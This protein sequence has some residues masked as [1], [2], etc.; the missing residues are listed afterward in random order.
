MRARYWFGVV[1]LAALGGLFVGRRT[2]SN[3]GVSTTERAIPIKGGSPNVELDLYSPPRNTTQTLLVFLQGNDPDEPDERADYA[4]EVGHMFQGRGVDVAAISFKA[5]P[6]ASLR[7]CAE[8]VALAISEI[9]RKHSFGRIVLAGRGLG[10]WAAA[11]LALDSD[12]WL[13][14]AGRTRPI[15]GVIG[16]RGRYKQAK[17]A[18]SPE[19]NIR[20]GAPPFLLLSAGND[21]P[22]FPRNDR[23][24]A[25]EL[26]RAGVQVE[27]HVVP[28]RDHHSLTHW[29][30]EANDLGDLVA[31]FV[32]RGPTTLQPDA[33][34]LELQQRWDAKP[35]LD[36]ADLRADASRIVRR[37][38]DP[39]LRKT[40]D[41][42][43]SRFAYVLNTMP[44]RT[45]E[46]IDLMSWLASRPE[47]EV[48]KGDH[49][50]ITNRRGEQLYFTRAE[51]EASK[52][53]IVVGIDDETNLYRLFGYYRLKHD[54]S[55]KKG[56]QQPMPLMIRPLGAFL[57]FPND[58]PRADSTYARYTLTA[59]S[60]RW[61]ET[62]PLAA[63]ADLSATLRPT[64]LG[65]QGCLKCHSFRGAGARAHHLLSSTGE[66]YG[67][68]ALPLEE[69]PPDVL[70]RFLYEQDAVARGFDVT[71]LMVAKPVAD[72]LSALVASAR[73]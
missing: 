47:S 5:G 38:A 25:Q 69:Y 12:I 21:D 16:M 56:P 67:A 30:G 35:P 54:Y 70:R 64:M 34:V 41:V 37:P 23:D 29:A 44:G 39:A 40:V 57:H 31:E 65:D 17:S 33:G 62:D 32:T 51:L 53:V 48:G 11:M 7:A 26:T 42:L 60:F 6:D 9:D 14:G 49:L 61:S 68:F 4:A 20:T 73:H 18:D 46:S 8:G 19:W 58:S 1:A 27:R 72:E 63:V 45:Y 71:P 10:A 59:K 43:F 66:A 52:P 22:E 3:D 28:Y 2:A 13:R 55:W 36:L 15:A 24:F 50:V